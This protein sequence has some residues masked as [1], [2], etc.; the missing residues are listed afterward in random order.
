MQGIKMSSAVSKL[1][2]GSISLLT[3]HTFPQ[4]NHNDINLFYCKVH[5]NHISSI[6]FV[7]HDSIQELALSLSIQ[8]FMLTNQRSPFLVRLLAMC[9]GEL[10]AIIAQLMCKCL[11]GRWKCQREVKKKLPLALFQ[12]LFYYAM[13]N[14]GLFSRRQPQ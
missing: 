7:F 14:F 10:S 3:T 6:L 9:R 5:N 11:C 1:S 13:S 8:Q 4:L 12:L 2:S